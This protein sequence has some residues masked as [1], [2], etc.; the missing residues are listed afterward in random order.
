MAPDNCADT[1]P[2]PLEWNMPFKSPTVGAVE[3]S[4]VTLCHRQTPGVHAGARWARSEN[5]RCVV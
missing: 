4:T 1:Y 3:K 5:G 2:H